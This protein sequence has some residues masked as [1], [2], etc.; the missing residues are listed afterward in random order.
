M[1]ELPEIVVKIVVDANGFFA[2]VSRSF[3]VEKSG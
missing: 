2:A 3:I 1:P